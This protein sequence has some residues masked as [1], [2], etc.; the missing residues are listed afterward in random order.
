MNRTTR[1]K[2]ARGSRSCHLRTGQLIRRASGQCS[3]RCRTSAVLLAVEEFTA[4]AT[5]AD[6]LTIGKL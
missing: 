4:G 3:I 6:K 5:A 1:P 2:R